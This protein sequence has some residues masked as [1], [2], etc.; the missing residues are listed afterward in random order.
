MDDKPEYYD[1]HGRYY[2]N[3]P[4]T[5]DNLPGYYDGSENEI[6]YINFPHKWI[7]FGMFMIFYISVCYK[8]N[9][10]RRDTDLYFFFV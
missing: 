10:F 5:E 3:D 1:T 8:R 7:Y 2:F 4:G 9:G 6:D